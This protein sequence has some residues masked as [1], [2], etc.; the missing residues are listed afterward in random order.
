[1]KSFASDNYAS[2]HPEALKA[3]MRVNDGHAM[4]YGAD[5]VTQEAQAKIREVFGDCES[6]FVFNGTGANV[7]G[8]SAL[9]K[10]YEAVICTEQSHISVDECGAVERIVGVK[11]VDL[12]APS[13]KIIPEQIYAATLNHGNEHQVQ[14]RVLSLTQS[15]EKGTLYSLS[16]LQAL[17][18]A[19]KD[20][21]L[22]VH[23]DGAR[24]ANAVAA[25]GVNPREI[26]DAAGVDVL[27][28]GGT[29]NG[30][31]MAEAVVVFNPEIAKQMKFY[32]KQNMQLASKMR[33]LSA[34]FLVYF[35]FWLENAKHAN[36]MAQKLL[37]G[38][39]NFSQIEISE[40]TE[41]NAVFAKL[42]REIIRPLQEKH[43]FYV[44]DETKNE[45]RL[46]CSFDTSDEDIDSFVGT[47][48]GFLKKT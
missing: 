17:K 10:S 16:E 40:K 38:L 24:F 12:A 20:R 48:K 14:A 37:K 39:Q 13:A 43:P 3:M 7:V 35:D 28:L 1:M 26:I 23:M 47:L 34:Q 32:R 11:L 42:P 30:L 19:A 15:T 8:L 45:V 4:A 5:S 2:V 31:M 46:M 44:W 21:G 41:V 22:F 6:F 36:A 29:K 33:Y 25:L 18:K 9:L 27:S